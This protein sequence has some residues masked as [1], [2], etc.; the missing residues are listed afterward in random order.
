MKN[1]TSILTIIGS[2][3]LGLLYLNRQLWAKWVGHIEAGVE[4]WGQLSCFMGLVFMVTWLISQKYPKTEQ[5]LSVQYGIIVI[6]QL[7]PIV[8]WL[9][10][11]GSPISDGDQALIAHWAFAT[12][13]IIMVG[14]SILGLFFIKG[15]A[16][17]MQNGEQVMKKI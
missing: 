6:L 7:M 16:N 14:I 5:V 3:L 2:I 9:M 10:F 11:S 1:I 8:S 15:T 12:P 13:H 17:S 4:P